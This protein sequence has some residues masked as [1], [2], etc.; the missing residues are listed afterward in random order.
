MFKL[1][2]DVEKSLK[3]K[4]PS[5]NITRFFDDLINEILE[6][7]FKDGACSI[8]RFGKFISFS[9]YS[10]AKGKYRVRFKFISAKSF[11]QK[12]IDD[13]FILQNVPVQAANKFDEK[14]KSI[15]ENKQIEKKHNREALKEASNYE[16]KIKNERIARNEILDALMEDN[17]D[18]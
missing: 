1:P 16:R 17:N 10:K 13:E 11:T 3:R 6:K 4:Y 15:C 12:I 9:R 2:I 8:I 5:I 14:N 7:T 18:Q